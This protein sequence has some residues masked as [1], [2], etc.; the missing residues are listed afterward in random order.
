MTR[1]H[2][3]VA[4]AL[5]ALVCAVVLS[6]AIPALALDWE[7]VYG[8][9]IILFSPGQASWEWVLT[10]SDHSAAPSV[11]R[12]KSCKDCH[13]GE[14]KD[15]GKLIASGKKLEPT[16][17]E[18]RR[19]FLRL[20]VKAVVDDDRLYVRLAWA[21]LPRSPDRKMDPDYQSKVALMFT[22][23]TVKSAESA[24][25][26]GACHNDMI[27]MPDAKEDQDLTKYLF[28]SRTEITRSGGGENYKS[29]GELEQLLSEGRFLE[30]WRAKLNPG[31]P[32]AA[33]DG[34]VL[35]KRHENEAPAISAISAESE[36]RDGEWVVVLSRKLSQSGKGYL[37][38]V[39]G[40]VYSIG[41]SVHEDFTAGRFHYV[42]LEYTLGI[43][44]LEADIVAERQ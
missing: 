44:N 42:S 30:L 7:A 25:C 22:D 5:A 13:G 15:I 26:W 29:D 27:G 40:E 19:G 20:N 16:P 38:F 1:L 23:G 21:G 10:E 43:D 11:R 33:V 37:P 2:K 6:G 18:G 39:S 24:G 4:P 36:F 28:A 35:D 31:E 41:F 32:A 12:E 3:P 34:Y 14:E 17:I 9:D 8:E